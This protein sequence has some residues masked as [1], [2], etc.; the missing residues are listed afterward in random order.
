M[1]FPLLIIDVG[2]MPTPKDT[3]IP[4]TMQPSTW[5]KPL[6]GKDTVYMPFDIPTGGTK[7]IANEIWAK[8]KSPSTQPDGTAFKATSTVKLQAIVPDLNR[9]LPHFEPSQTISIQYP[10]RFVIDEFKW[11][12]TIS[13]GSSTSLQWAVRISK[14]M[15]LWSSM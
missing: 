3:L 1:I 4:V 5:I 11:M 9:K 10:V 15:M 7:R 6:P 2:G 13:Q 14:S 12:D 8:I